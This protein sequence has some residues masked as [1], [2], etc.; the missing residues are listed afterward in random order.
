MGG[1]RQSLRF[2]FEKLAGWLT[3]GLP[4]AV[5]SRPFGVALLIAGH[6]E[7]TGPVL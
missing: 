6:E 7:E 4:A 1:C 3:L 5:Q 2:V